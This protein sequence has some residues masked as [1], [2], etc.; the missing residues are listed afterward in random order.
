MV[1]PPVFRCQASYSRP[2]V[3]RCRGRRHGPHLTQGV[4]ERNLMRSG[5]SAPRNSTPRQQTLSA[6]TWAMGRKRRKCHFSY[7]L[8]H[9]RW[10]RGA[11]GG[12]EGAPNYGRWRPTQ[13]ALPDLAPYLES[14]FQT[15][16]SPHVRGAHRRKANRS[17]VRDPVRFGQPRRSGYSRSSCRR[18]HWVLP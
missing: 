5:W 9:D 11:P 3:A 4:Q 13:A 18:I 6:R 8:I 7:R 15:L 2:Y 14:S 16:G 17:S 10:P 1:P 12:R